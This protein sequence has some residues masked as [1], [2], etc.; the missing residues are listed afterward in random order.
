MTKNPRQDR[1]YRMRETAKPGLRARKWPYFPGQTMMLVG[2][3]GILAG[4]ALPWA[5]VLGQY[6]W[7]SPLALTW[8]LWAGMMALAASVARWRL[9]VLVSSAVGGCTA[10]VFAVWQTAR[11]VQSCLS[12]HCLPGPGV[13]LLLAGGLATLYEGARMAV[14][15]GQA[16]ATIESGRG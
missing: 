2:A 7:A 6:L 10:V 13:V 16:R 5:V 3:L 9:L 1:Q 15:R 12:V 11:I 4:T 8:T 14:R